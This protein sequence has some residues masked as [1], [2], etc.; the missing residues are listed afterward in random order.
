MDALVTP[1]A[2]EY[3]VVHVVRSPLPG[4]DDMVNLG[5]VAKYNILPTKGAYTARLAP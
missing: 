4:G 3:Q 5:T 2:E 1:T